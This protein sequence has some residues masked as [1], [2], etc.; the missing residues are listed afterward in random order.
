MH[1]QSF[2]TLVEVEVTFAVN[3]FSDTHSPLK[4]HLAF[5]L[6]ASSMS[7]HK[8]MSSV[9]SGNFILYRA[10]TLLETSLVL[11]HLN[12][13]QGLIGV[14]WTDM[15]SYFYVNPFFLCFEYFKKHKTVKNDLISK[16]SGVFMK[17]CFGSRQI[18]LNV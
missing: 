6:L 14:K 11:V 2:S 8:P 18:C 1:Q 15:L 3:T 5:I 17:I 7:C 16:N 13:A 12:A 4:P 9:N 10:L